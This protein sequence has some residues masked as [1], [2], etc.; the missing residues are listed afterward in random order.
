LRGD[1]A[2]AVMLVA[3]STLVSLV[4]MP[5]ICALPKAC[6]LAILP[7]RMLSWRDAAWL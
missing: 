2:Q 3:S 7:N 6:A 5:P 1:V 4:S